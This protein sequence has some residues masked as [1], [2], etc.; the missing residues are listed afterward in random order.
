MILQAYTSQIV[1]MVMMALAIGADRISTQARR[2]DIING[3]SDLPS[4]PFNL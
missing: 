3:L 2:E 4:M 1:V